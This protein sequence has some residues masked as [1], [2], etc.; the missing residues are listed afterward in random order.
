LLRQD[1]DVIML[2]EIR[3]ADT[4]RIAT[5]AALTGHVVLSTLHTNDAPSAITRLFNIG[6]EPYLVAASVRGV[7]AQRLV[8]KIC[9][10]CKEEAEVNPALRRTAEDQLGPIDTFYRGAGCPKCRHT[11]FA[12]RIGIFELFVPSDAMLDLIAGG[13][14]LN[15]LRKLATEEGY[16][17]LR[18]DGLEKVK[19]GLTTLEEVLYVTAA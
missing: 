6:V 18:A 4:A 16:V 15:E 3:D 10:H 19:A 8:R 14:G 1:P 7:L 2:G 11:G 13:A 9:S 12:G 5:Q 17:R